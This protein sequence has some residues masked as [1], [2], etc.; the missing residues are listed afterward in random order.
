MGAKRQP[1]YRIVVAES[2]SPRDGRFIETVGIYNPKTQPMTLRVDSE[3]AKY[4]LER[5]A[6]PTDTVRSLLVRVGAV[7]GRISKEGIAE[8]YVTE[9]PSRG[10]TPEIMQAHGATAESDAATEAPA[11][12]AKAA[13][14]PVEEAPVAAV[15]AAPAE[16]AAAEEA[17]ED[18]PVAEAAAEEPAAEEATEPE[19]KA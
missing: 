4:W 1:S 11:K 18:A 16:E 12:K 17:A 2:R 8:G 9:V 10:T 5:G 7:P 14:A 15:E 6:Q 3:R 19:A 13:A